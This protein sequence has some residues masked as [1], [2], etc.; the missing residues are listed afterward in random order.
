MPTHPDAIE[1]LVVSFISWVM[2]ILGFI[3]YRF[4]HWGNPHWWLGLRRR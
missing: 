4:A 2:Q 1:I 3:R